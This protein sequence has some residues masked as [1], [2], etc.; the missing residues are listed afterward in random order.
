MIRASPAIPKTRRSPTSRNGRPDCRSIAPDS[1]FYYLSSRARYYRPMSQLFAR[2]LTIALLACPAAGAETVHFDQVMQWVQAERDAGP[3]LAP[4]ETLRREH[5]DQL[6][7]FVPPVF[8][9]FLDFPD[10]EAVLQATEPYEPH[11]SYRAATLQYGDQTELAEDRSLRNY[12]AGQPFPTERI[13]AAPAE[14]AAY[15]IAWNQVYR[16]QNYGY[17]S[18][19]IHQAF[20]RGGD[21]GGRD[22]PALERAFA[23][24]GLIERHLTQRYQRVYL[25]HLA[26]LPEDHFTLDVDQ[27]ERLQYM[28]YI[29][30]EHPFEMR[31]ST[32]VIERSLDPH[33]EDQ[34]N[35]YLPTERRVRR[36]SSKERADSFQGSEFTIDDFE[37]FSGR[38]LDYDWI[39]H[40]EKSVLHIADARS[41]P[42]VFFGPDSRIP[43]NRWQLRRC[44]V[45]EQHPHYEEHPYGRKLVLIDVETY[46]IPFTLI[47]DREDRLWKVIYSVY[48]WPYEG[49]APADAPPTGTVP[50]WRSG[51]SI[52]VQTGIAT[53]VW[54][55]ETTVPD[56]NP[57][58]VERLFS[59]SNLTGGR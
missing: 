31:G 49:P 43:R 32:V 37:G 36:L 51:V 11:S 9:E 42:L 38:V 41:E 50:H 34:V 21:T 47:F 53:H 59:I 20:L 15:M 56:V 44:Y 25:N 14:Q 39:Y 30:Y 35:A 19:R 45:I 16:W 17:A 57:R 33:E 3:A 40:G 26:Q 24:S 6:R 8:I 13:A 27:A 29:G 28:D 10:F 18:E 1:H 55:D 12:V 58:A 4:G 46:N 52:N 5:L 7:P 54:S 48:E 22:H 23:G 2:A